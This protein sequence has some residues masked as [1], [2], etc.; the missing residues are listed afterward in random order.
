ME[1]TDVRK[2]FAPFLALPLVVAGL[3]A[4]AQS[5]PSAD[6][7]IKSLRPTGNLV[8][9]GTRG[10]RV[11]GA[12]PAP[13]PAVPVA[14]GQPHAATSHAAAAAPA[15]PAAPSANLTVNF[16][17]GSADLT[18]QAV[19]ALNELG[20]ALSSSDLAGYKF[21]IEGHTDTVG[22]PESNR[23]LSERRAQAVVSYITSHFGVD[24]SRLQA[25]G[26]G[27]E[28]LAVPTPAQTPEPRNRRVLVVNLGA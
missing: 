9:G 27:E 2:M 18:P 21:R 7:I 13:S 1:G 19:Q 16:A 24:A 11:G 26:M 12:P 20:R 6:Q 15:Q 5:S 23:A 17:S 3:P 4:L 10:I 28:D 8:S 25:I 22:T 14:T